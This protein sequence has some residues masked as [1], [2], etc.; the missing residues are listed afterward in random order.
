MLHSK[1][2]TGG[3]SLNVMRSVK[4]LQEKHI[5]FELNCHDRLYLN[6]FVPI[7]C[8]LGG[9][10]TVIRYLLDYAVPLP[11]AFREVRDLFICAVHHFAEENGLKIHEFS[12]KEQNSK[13]QIAREHLERF[14]W[15]EGVFLIGK[16]QEKVKVPQAGWVPRKNNPDKKW[17]QLRWGYV[18]VNQYYFYFRD[19]DWG[20]GFIKFSS[21]APFCGRFYINGHEYVK[22]QLEKKGICFEALDNGIGKCEDPKAAQRIADGITAK[23]LEKLIRKWSR[24]VP[25]PL[26][27]MPGRRGNLSLKYEISMLQ[28]EIARTQLWKRAADGLQFFEQVIRENIDLGR[29]EK[30]GVIFGKQIRK[31]TR[32]NHRFMSRVF[33]YGAIP[34]FHVYFKTSKLKQY[35]KEAKALRNEVTIN[36]P[37]DFGVGKML[38]TENFRSLREVGLDTIK[39]LLRVETLAH[40]PSVSL[41]KLDSIEEAAEVAGR[42]VSPLPRSNKRVRAQFNALIACHLITGGFRNRDLKSRVAHLLGK[43]PDEITTNQM[44]YDL[45]RLRGHGIIEKVEGTNRYELTEEGLHLALFISRVERR[46]YRDGMAE[47]WDDDLVD[48]NMKHAL[49]QFDREVELHMQRNLALAG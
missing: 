6:L 42:R 35:F 20:V 26:D 47:L 19:E 4:D 28:T 40:D 41:V 9:I 34:V 16:A 32:Q 24:I 15:K 44:T 11:S 2:T 48:S 21:Y 23:K 5:D 39:R 12:K 29:P 45:R 18:M 13:E 17:L 14:P 38:T 1:I 33:T 46:V 36:N 49:Q 31:A 37:R 30:V 10:V 8:S 22:N 27:F 43:M 7:L 25:N 3:T